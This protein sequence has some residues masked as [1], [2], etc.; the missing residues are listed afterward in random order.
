MPLAWGGCV[1]VLLS[2]A[3]SAAAAVIVTGVMLSS[4]EASDVQRV[5][6]CAVA[7]G[8]VTH[9]ESATL[10]SA[11][12]TCSPPL[13]RPLDHVR[14]QT[15]HGGGKVGGQCAEPVHLVLGQGSCFGQA[16]EGVETRLRFKKGG[17]E[18]R[19]G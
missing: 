17:G 15:R 5:P 9:N 16:L 18:G 2:N 19:A 3:R 6:T 4:C 11:G 13:A 7:A 8:R 1:Q 14:R 12:G 10:V